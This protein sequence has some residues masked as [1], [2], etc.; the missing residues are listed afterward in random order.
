MKKSCIYIDQRFHEKTGSTNFLFSIL[1]KRFEVRR[2]F[3]DGFSETA[4]E[5]LKQLDADLFVVFQYDF[6]APILLALGKRV[7]VVPMYDGT[8]EIFDEHWLLQRSALFLNFSRTLQNRHQILGLNAHYAQAFPK[9]GSYSEVRSRY[10][11]PRF[12]LWE[13][14]PQSGI[15]GRWLAQRLKQQKIQPELVHLHLAPDPGQN[16][17]LQPETARSVFHPIKISTTTWFP[18]REQMA[19]ALATCNV[20]VAPRAAEGIGW[21]FLEAMASGMVVLSKSAPTM[22][23]YIS[24]WDTGILIDND[25]PELDA[26]TIRRIGA[27]AT[28]YISDGYARWTAEQDSIADRAYEYACSPVFAVDY[29]FE[30]VVMLPRM[31]FW[32]HA[33]YALHVKHLIGARQQATNRRDDYRR[34]LE[35]FVLKHP[36]LAA[37]TLAVHERYKE[38]KNARKGK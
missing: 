37:Y 10:L 21:S 20:Y 13:R 27:A 24:N 29:S 11:A 1:E 30:D 12:F 36:Q 7:L 18:T 26:S 14:R 38:R 33:E 28:D 4:L 31:F 22:N 6:L 34:R 2:H 3:L 16:S 19:N 5:S 17:S 23:E 15:S 9:P 8:G 32:S 25:L 35:M